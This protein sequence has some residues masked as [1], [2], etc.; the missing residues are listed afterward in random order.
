MCRGPGVAVGLARAQNNVQGDGGGVRAH[1]GS[2]VQRDWTGV[3]GP[4]RK[5]LVGKVEELGS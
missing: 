3:R 2:A 5:G 1:E 4:I